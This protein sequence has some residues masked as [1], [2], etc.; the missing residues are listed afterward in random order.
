VFWPAGT[1]AAGTP[2][3]PSH[4]I[5]QQ[6][7]TPAAGPA[8]VTTYADNADGAI[9][10]ITPQAGTAQTMQ[11]DDL[12]RL[13]LAATGTQQTSYIYDA[14]GNLLLRQ[15]P[16]ATTLFLPNEQISQGSSGAF[17]GALRYYSIGGKT[18]AVRSSSGAVN[19]LD[20]DEEGTATV[21]VNVSSLAVT[22]RHYDPY[23]NPVTATAGTA[24]WPG[25]DGFQQGTPDSATGLENIG[26]RQYLPGISA[27]ISP[28]P[29]LTPANPRDLNH[30]AYA[31]D[32]PP[33]S[34][35]PSGQ[36]VP[37][38][39]HS[40]T[41]SSTGSGGTVAPVYGA[42]SQQ[43]PAFAP[44][45]SGRLLQLGACPSEAGAAGTTAAEVKQSLI[46][47]A[48]IIGGSLFGPLADGFLSLI[49]GSSAAA[50]GAAAAEDTE[51]ANLVF[52]ALNSQ[53]AAT[54]ARG[55]GIVAKNPEGEWSLAEHLVKGSSR[56]SW[57]NDPWI[58]TTT[59]QSV[60]EGFN[61]SGSKLGVVAINLDQV[62]S[63]AAEGWKIYPRL[64]GEAG[65]PYYYSI[66]QQEVSIFQSIP[67]EAILGF[68]G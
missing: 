61:E 39:D 41:T 24:T 3:E 21:A 50:E 11:W 8:A 12:G 43:G 32:A 16:A 7:V 1:G 65:L 60:A 6:T 29:I 68:V 22:R 51:T 56:A 20:S 28:D 18:I 34:E 59:D 26:A 23:G 2:Q 57:A 55:E 64:A 15:D 58:S 47:A 49:G 52:R 10:K 4:G 17:T 37:P 45:C 5:S 33:T 42:G 46:G 19:Y 63:A 35:D 25:N 36:Q 67:Q 31:Q 54:V 44:G 13:M 27:F 30:Y 14:D 9:K 40:G 38:P 48:Y 66:W 53:D 62:P